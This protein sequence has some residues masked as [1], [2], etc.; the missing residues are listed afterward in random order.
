MATQ[1]YDTLCKIQVI[2]IEFDLETIKN[3]YLVF[4]TKDLLTSSH[5]GKFRSSTLLNE[6]KHRAA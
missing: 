6:S 2:V 3:D 4:Y 1:N 5:R